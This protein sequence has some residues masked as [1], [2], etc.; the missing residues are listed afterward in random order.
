MYYI[1]SVIAFNDCKLILGARFNTQWPHKSG[2]R[3]TYRYI[4]LSESPTI[5]SFTDD[6][7]EK[8]LY[9]DNTDYC[10]DWCIDHLDLLSYMYINHNCYNNQNY[11]LS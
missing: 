11:I 8:V 10:D 5:F 1:N 7:S 2:T 3:D 6:S 9:L 4:K